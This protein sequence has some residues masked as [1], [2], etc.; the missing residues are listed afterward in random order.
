VYHREEQKTEITVIICPGIDVLSKITWF[1]PQ[2]KKAQVLCKRALQ[3]L[4]I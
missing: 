1:R 3:C 4:A 2:N